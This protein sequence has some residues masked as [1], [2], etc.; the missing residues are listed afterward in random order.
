MNS[1][2]DRIGDWSLTCNIVRKPAKRFNLVECW[3]KCLIEIK[4]FISQKNV[5]QTS[6]NMGAKRS[7]IVETTNNNVE[8]FS[9]GLI[10]YV[11]TSHNQSLPYFNCYFY[12]LVIVCLLVFLCFT[13]SSFDFVVFVVLLVC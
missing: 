13:L 9:R 10:V 1:Q 12:Y 6:S 8:T 11:N 4:T 3:T 7:N 2:C 5:E